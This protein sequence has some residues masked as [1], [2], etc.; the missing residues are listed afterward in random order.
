MIIP[1]DTDKFLE[2]Y[3]NDSDSYLQGWDSVSEN[4]KSSLFP[5]LERYS[6]LYA[7]E[8]SNCFEPLFREFDVQNVELSMLNQD[9]I[10]QID[11]MNREEESSES[12]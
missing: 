11:I 5:M 2:S 6:E 4:L 10:E 12:S 1:D 8:C 3:I 9:L 7:K